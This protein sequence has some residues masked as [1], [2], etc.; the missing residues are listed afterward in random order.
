MR[1]N[2]GHPMFTVFFRTDGAP[3]TAER[4]IAAQPPVFRDALSEAAAQLA[5]TGS[6][7]G[8]HSARST[9]GEWMIW[10]DGPDGRRHG[11]TLYVSPLEAPAIGARN[12]PPPR[13]RLVMVL[14]PHPE[15]FG[16][17]P[18]VI[19][20]SEYLRRSFAG[21]IRAQLLEALRRALAGEP[22]D[23][24]ETVEYTPRGVIL[25]ARSSDTQIRTFDAEVRFDWE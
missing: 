18:V 7:D 15:R 17:S 2:R 22:A 14:D 1:I 16:Q 21:D 24:N 12:P 4:F 8:F 10:L 5:S 25:R 3:L 6:I 9:S 11:F 23:G 13:R 20:A 19:E